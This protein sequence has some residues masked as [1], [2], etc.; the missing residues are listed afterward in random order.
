MRI[1]KQFEQ[2]RMK[3]NDL[4]TVPAIQGLFN[5]ELFTF[6]AKTRPMPVDWTIINDAFDSNDRA[7]ESHNASDI[8]QVEHCGQF[9]RTRSQSRISLNEL[10]FNELSQPITSTPIKSARKRPWSRQS[11]RSSIPPPISAASSYSNS[12]N[13]CT[14]P[15]AFKNPATPNLPIRTASPP[16]TFKNP[17]N[18]I[19]SS[20]AVSPPS[21]FKNPTNKRSSNRTVSPPPAFK[22]SSNR[23]SPSLVSQPTNFDDDDGLC[24][25]SQNNS[26]LA[27]GENVPPLQHA[28]GQKIMDSESDESEGNAIEQI[29][30]MN[31]TIDKGSSE[32]EII[33]KLIRLWRKNV[34]PIQMENLLKK[35][36]NRFQAAKTFAALL[37]KYHN[38]VYA[39]FLLL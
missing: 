7:A 23:N 31:T 34:Q 22:D 13:I 27:N 19:V 36:C 37:C 14:P 8:L 18:H 11:D 26:G 30:L 33:S 21:A 2:L 24:G 10:S 25:F 1:S 29:D 3:S 9:I 38:P 17:S 39:L 5:Q 4:F 16:S 12:P 35:G 6:G 32:Y 15:T 20:A 28:S